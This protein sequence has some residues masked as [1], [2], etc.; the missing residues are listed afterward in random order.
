MRLLSELKLPA[1][2]SNL[3]DFINLVSKCAEEQGV[4]P[5]RIT[6]IG[7]ATEEA[8]VN[9]CMYAYQ[10]ATG[11]VKVSCM[12]DDENRFV[13]EIEDTGMAFD[14]LGVGD[15]NLTDD[16]AEREVG[17]LGVFIIKELMNEVQYRREDNKNIL[18][19]VT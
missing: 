4:S 7:V 9:I 2:I 8:L 1:E 6:E 3:R 5:G 17:G 19:L 13:I 11:D 10:G 18:K 12:L 15:P 14:L 16:I